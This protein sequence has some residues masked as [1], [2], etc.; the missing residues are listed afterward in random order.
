[1]QNYI[2]IR[3][4]GNSVAL[5][6][7]SRPFKTDERLFIHKAHERYI[8]IDK[9]TGLR[10]TSAPKLKDIERKYYEIKTSYEKFIKGDT[11]HKLCEQFSKLM[12]DTKHE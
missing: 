12:E 1:M 11:Y 2:Q 8:L 10:L 9:L 7:E 4:D 5:L 3:K 6:V